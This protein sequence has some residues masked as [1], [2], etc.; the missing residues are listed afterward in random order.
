M[1][2]VFVATSAKA[3]GAAVQEA[4][5]HVYQL[6][7]QL[8]HA[9]HLAR[10]YEGMGAVANVPG[11]NGARQNI[12]ALPGQIDAAKQRVT[13]LI[14]RLSE[15]MIEDDR[16]A[17]EG[18][19]FWF[20]RFMLSLQIGNGAAFL[21]TVAGLLQADKDVLSVMAVLVWPPATYFGLGVGAAG[22]LPLLMFARQSVSRP[23]W[24]RIAHAAVLL[25]VTFSMGLFALGA[26]SVVVEIRQL[27]QPAV[28]AAQKAAANKA[29]AQ[30]PVAA[31]R[32]PTSGQTSSPTH[33]APDPQGSLPEAP[34]SKP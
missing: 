5:E 28:A 21:A 31:P 1:E 13:D 20:R 30:E 2:D 8:D 11:L 26:G 23:T 29:A 3:L 17:R 12:Q 15:R 22:L 4:V 7:A 10:P 9:H 19:D 24:V 27:G 14:K 6:E 33:A 18:R 25:F 34:K 32:A 16:A